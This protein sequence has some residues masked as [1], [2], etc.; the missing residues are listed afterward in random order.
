MTDVPLGDADRKIISGPAP[1][2]IG[3]RRR[4]DR[5]PRC[6]LC[7]GAAWWNGRRV[8]HPVVATSVPGAVE[9]RELALALAKC[10]SCLVGFTCYPPGFYPRRQYQ[11]DVVAEVV[12]AVALG[13]EPV[14]QACTACSAS[15]TSTRRWLAWVA[16]LAKASELHAAA[17]QLDAST[18]TVASTGVAP[19]RTQAAAVLTAFEVLGAAVVRAGVMVVERTGLG[20]VLGWQHR[21]HGDVYGLVAG[22]TR[23]SP[24]MAAGGR[25]SGS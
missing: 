23:F 6:G 17:A 5:P 8:V 12:A 18:A 9:R 24:A 15:A 20:R 22:P 11:L 1:V 4:D 2:V 19:P 3:R 16:A 25:P 13:G 10:S 21:R 7:R 14:A